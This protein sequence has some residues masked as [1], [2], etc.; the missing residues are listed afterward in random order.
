MIFVNFAFE[1]G[2]VWLEI[3]LF[4]NEVVFS[5]VFYYTCR[6]NI[7]EIWFIPTGYR[8]KALSFQVEIFTLKNVLRAFSD[9]LQDLDL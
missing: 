8:W 1:S 9:Y 6:N 3:V 7:I 5:S 2:I 4:E